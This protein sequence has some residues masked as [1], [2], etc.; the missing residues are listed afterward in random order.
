[1]KT[2]QLVLFLIAGQFG[3]P[4]VSVRGQEQFA[5]N[6]EERLRWHR[7]S[8]DIVSSY[9]Y[10]KQLPAWSKIPTLL[11]WVNRDSRDAGIEVAYSQLVAL[12]RID[13]GHPQHPPAG[14]LPSETVTYHRVQRSGAWERWWKAVG[15]PYAERVR[16]LGRQNPEAWKLVVRDDGPPV[17]DYKV[18]IPGEWVLRT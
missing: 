10:L 7:Y 18:T 14:G 17:P 4:A 6:G 3:L 2:M 11:E 13:F 9:P 15:Q 1:M 8:Y 16:T 5:A 12:S